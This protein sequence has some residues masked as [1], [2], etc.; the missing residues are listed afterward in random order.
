MLWFFERQDAWL[1]YEIRRQVDGHAY[2]LVITHPDG[3]QD[4]EQFGDS[5]ELIERSRHLQ[6]T[7]VAAGWHAPE[8][9]GRSRSARGDQRPTGPAAF[10]FDRD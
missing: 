3:H 1:R 6:E 10:D 7:L 4:I 2:E 9:S 8:M 5:R